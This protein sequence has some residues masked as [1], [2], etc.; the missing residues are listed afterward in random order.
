[1]D[2][3][4]L[5]TRL[6]DVKRQ[7]VKGLTYHAF[8]GSILPYGK[9]YLLAYRDDTEWRIQSVH[10]DRDFRVQTPVTSMGLYMNTDPRLFYW[11][12]RIWMTTSYCG[13]PGPA[14]IEAWP[15]TPEPALNVDDDWLYQKGGYNFK[16]TKVH[17][18]PGYQTRAEKN[19][20][21]F[22][23]RNH[24]HYV[25]SFHPHRILRVSF[26]DKSVSLV[27]TTQFEPL[28]IRPRDVTEVRLSTQPVMLADGSYLSTYHY[29]GRWFP[30]YY[31]GFY[32]F[33]G[34][35]P[36]KVIDM[37]PAPVFTPGMAHNTDQRYPMACVFLS[38][39]VIEDDVVRISGGVND[40]TVPIFTLSLKEILASLRKVK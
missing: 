17:D 18:F 13:G 37:S 33:E 39:M 29:R 11:Q 3:H 15:M 12:G 6:P 4:Y 23:Y 16:F 32:R 14:Q 5:Q 27:A 40:T 22:L 36:W 20:A 19:W 38:S 9:G 8:N 24:L 28:P 1:M 31:S 21:P 2:V 7:D 25:Y 35:P 34:E 10:L 30:E 26:R